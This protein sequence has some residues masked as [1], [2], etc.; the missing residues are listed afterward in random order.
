MLTEDEIYSL[1]YYGRIMQ[2]K[3]KWKWI[4][5]NIFLFFCVIFFMSCIINCIE[6]G[7]LVMTI[8]Q[9]IILISISLFT[10]IVGVLALF[11]QNKKLY[12]KLKEKENLSS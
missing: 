12:K 10:S 9:M 3:R 11:Y 8:R 6:N 1:H 4:I 5:A 2:R 7:K